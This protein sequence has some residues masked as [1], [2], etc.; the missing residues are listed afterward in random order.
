MEQNFGTRLRELRKSRKLSQKDLADRLSISFQSVSKWEN[1]S[2]LPN[3]SLIPAIAGILKVSCDLLIGHEGT[4]NQNKYNELYGGET[5]FWPA[6]P[7]ALSYKLLELCPASEYRNV[8][9]LG[10][11]EGHDAVFF[12]VNRYHVTAIDTAQ[13][14][15][16]TGIRLAESNRVNV[17]FLCADIR[18]YFPKEPLDLVYG[19]RILHY[20]NPEERTRLVNHY[21]DRTRV[22]GIHAF[23]V[24]VS[25]KFFLPPAPDSKNDTTFKYKSGEL[26]THYYDWE[27]LYVN[28]EIVDCNSSGIPHKHCIDTIIAR[29]PPYTGK[30]LYDAPW[31]AHLRPKNKA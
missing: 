10:C 16:D 19:H 22:G 27:L 4:A 7:H 18:S 5:F 12:G 31:N 29:K 21:K 3:I 20:I 25:G 23:T 17:N 8:L 30:N 24:P 2:S 13:T 14:G 15:I 26:F 6:E 28:E 11:G 1:G 9:E